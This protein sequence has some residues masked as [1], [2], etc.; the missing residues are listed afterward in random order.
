[1]NNTNEFKI[2]IKKKKKKKKKIYIY[3]YSS[4]DI[5][6]FEGPVNL[7]WSAIMKTINENPAAFFEDGGWKFLSIDTDVKIKIK[8]Y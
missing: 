5:A 1:M 3:I 7:N 4:M 8:K 2:I 6:F